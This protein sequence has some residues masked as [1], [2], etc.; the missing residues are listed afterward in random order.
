MKKI[1]TRFKNL[2]DRTLTNPFLSA[3]EFICI[4]IA[5]IL[6]R[7]ILGCTPK[8]ELSFV[9]SFENII[10]RF[11]NKII[12][13]DSTA[14]I[15]IYRIINILCIS[16][17]VFLICFCYEFVRKK[18]SEF[19]TLKNI[20]KFLN[21]L[22]IAAYIIF[23]IWMLFKFEASMTFLYNLL[24]NIKNIIRFLTI[25]D[26]IST[27]PSN[28]FG[29]NLLARFIVFGAITY[30][31]LYLTNIINYFFRDKVTYPNNKSSDNIDDTN[32]KASD[33]IKS[34]E[35]AENKI[36]NAYNNSV[37]SG[38]R[39]EKFIYN[40]KKNK[41]NIANIFS[42]IGVITSI[43]IIILSINNP[44]T[45]EEGLSSKVCKFF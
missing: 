3:F 22:L 32:N 43:A 7:L 13:I 27:E 16:I 38:T 40:E 17:V 37:I 24:H 8:I 26:S 33:N 12:V 5:I 1:R 4:I 6:I 44:D 28:L 23:I 18:C 10:T 15:A 30:V 9:Q 39:F 29:F 21:C 36:N 45:T 41:L 19:K 20:V 11:I 42:L 34:S 25:Y 35:N 31:L 14:N 2:I